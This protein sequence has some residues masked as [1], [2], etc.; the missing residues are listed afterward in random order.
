[1]AH[2]RSC[3]GQHNIIRI[4]AACAQVPGRVG[5]ETRQA[6]LLQKEVSDIFQIMQYYADES[7]TRTATLTRWR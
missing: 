7:V 2:W 6:Q 3:D 1:M 5:A 4:Q